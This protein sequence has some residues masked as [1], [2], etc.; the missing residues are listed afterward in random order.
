MMQ[1]GRELEE[2]GQV[3]G[4][5]VWQRFKRI[6]FPLTS[7][8]FVAGF[9]LTFITTM[10][11]LSLIILLVTPQTQVLSSQ[12]MFYIENGSGQMANVVVL[13]LIA[14]VALGNFIITRFRGGSLKKGLGM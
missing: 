3:A 5:T 10:R 11:S 9:L 2:A 6:I 4:A 14:I 1:V 8:G 13:I 7:A 12:S